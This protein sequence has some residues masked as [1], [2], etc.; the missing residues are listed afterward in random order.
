MRLYDYW[1]SSSAYRVRIALRHKGLHHE[2]VAVNLRQGVHRTLDYLGHNRQGLV[3]TL[4]AGELQL[5]QSLAIVE[6]L[7]ETYPTPP[8]LPAEPAGKAVVRSLALQVA[9]EM[10]PLTNLRVLQYLQGRLGLNEQ[11]VNGWYRHWIAEGF[12]SLEPRL[13]AVAGRYC[14]GDAPTLADICLVPQV[15]NARRYNC[16]LDPFPTIR[17][18]EAACLK[19]PAFNEARPEL[20]PDAV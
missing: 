7:E 16:D 20:Q 18:I 3:P 11:D 14:H 12:G 15:Y 9:C 10:Q 4:E 17:R 5:S 2:S 13:A 1:R 19:L 8:L 6:W